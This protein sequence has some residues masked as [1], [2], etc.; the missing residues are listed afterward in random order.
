MTNEAL[1]MALA[2]ATKDELMEYAD[3]NN[4]TLSE[5]V[6]VLNHVVYGTDDKRE[7]LKALKANR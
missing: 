1:T 4:M 5:V 7:E 3:Y 6:T 2:V